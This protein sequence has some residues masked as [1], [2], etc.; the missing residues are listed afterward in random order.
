MTTLVWFRADLRTRD[1]AALHAAAL[2]GP[3]QALFVACPGEWRAHDDAPAKIDLIMR[4]LAV[5]RADLAALGIPFTILAVPTAQAMP[6]A[7]VRTAGDIRCDTIRFNRQYELDEARRD[8]RTIRLASASGVRT[9][10]HDDQS[11]LAPGFVRTR[12]GKPFTVFTPFK[13]AWMALLDERGGLADGTAPLQVPIARSPLPPPLDT[14]PDPIVAAFLTKGLPSPDRARFAALWPAGEHEAT[15]RLR[16]FVS[17]PLARYA[18]DRD[19]PDLVG[20]SALSPYLAIGAI[21]PRQCLAAA[22]DAKSRL[23]ASAA[24]SIDTW[25]SELIWR[26]FYIHVMAAFARVVMGRAFKAATDR[27]PWRHDESDFA[28][29]AE[30]RTGV[31]IVDAG[32]R[33][34]L[35]TGWMHNRLRMI[36]AMYL[37]KNLFIDWRRGE[38]H[39]MRHLVDGFFASNNGGWQ[40]SASTGTDAAPYFRMF[41]P[42]SQSRRVDPAGDHIRRWVPELTGVTGDAI[43]DP[44]D[45][46]FGLP[47]LARAGLDYP[48]PMADQAASRERVMAAFARA[49]ESEVRPSRD[50]ASPHPAPAA[51]RSLPRKS[52][53]TPPPSTPARSRGRVP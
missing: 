45:E 20:T 24:A 12:E 5:L 26:E 47:P 49:A 42:V 6:D 14:A 3:V 19:R 18:T 43:H 1:H 40:W 27:L 2:D 28:R 17:G 51:P 10:A 8:E 39:F 23:P 21:S 7:V 46:K 15:R 25:I 9:I 29:W 35:A 11:I 22:L 30:G 13:R 52:P 48:P 16:A 4:T 34:L 36:T 41:N 37:S 31:P 38:R 32:M 44:H 53:A 50:R 33:Q